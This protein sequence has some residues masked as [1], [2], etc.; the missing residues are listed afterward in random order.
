MKRISTIFIAVV[1]LALVL[2]PGVALANMGPHGGYVA[3]T[4]ACAGCHRAHTAP[5]A[6]TWEGTDGVSRS[7]LLL[8]SSSQL[9]QFCLTC[10]DSTS[11]GADTN[12][13]DGIYEGT[14]NG[15]VNA[16]LISGP[17]GREDSA[18]GQ[19]TWD[20]HNN[21]VTSSHL[22]N[23][24][25]WGAW[26]GGAYGSSSSAEATGNYPS[27]LGTGNKIVM[28]CGS[29][30]DPHGT[31]N[32]RLLKDQVNGVT[33]GGYDG[34]GAPT[35]YVVSAEPGFP[36]AGF[37]TATSYGS[38]V[39]NYTAAKYAKAP[40]LSTTKGM[41]GWCA[42]CH[43]TYMSVESTY[44]A[45]DGFGFVKRHRHP[46][47][48]ALTD[49]KGASALTVTSLTVDVPLEHD[50]ANVGTNDTSDWI[51]CM[52][53]HTAHGSVKTMSGFANV[54]DSVNDLQADSGEGGVQPTNDSALLRANNRTACQACHRK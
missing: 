30:H 41:S 49:Y 29:C 1:A 54:A 31:S 28:D 23:G 4:D 44:N 27:L 24:Q 6:M 43:T 3:N 48:V 17:F 38:Y 11:Q 25:S 7:S 32:Y 42:G 45:G 18:M 20:A 9:Y 12:V 19:G 16:D 5:G 26:G 36:A 13:L 39:P 40:S 34:A 50:P 51:G 21:K 52:T 47:N 33:V 14:V 2:V 53:C 37:A 15:T 10:H 46:M 8:T 35:P 22:I